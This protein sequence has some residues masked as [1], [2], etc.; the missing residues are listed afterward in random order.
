MAGIARALM[1]KPSIL[2][3]D[4]P[5]LGLAPKVVDEIFETIQGLRS[6][7]LGLL[8]VEQNAYQA[9]RI[10]DFGYVVEN[11]R[12]VRSGEPSQLLDLEQLRRAYFA[13]S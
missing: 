4:E 3:L 13:I 2:V 7:G 11:G 6:E 10:A 5:S 9:L 1:A 12:V 8:L